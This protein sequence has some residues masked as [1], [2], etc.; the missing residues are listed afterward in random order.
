MSVDRAQREV[1]DLALGL[2]RDQRVERFAK[3]HARRAMEPQVHDVET[4]DVERA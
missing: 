4:F 3:R 1:T 2:H